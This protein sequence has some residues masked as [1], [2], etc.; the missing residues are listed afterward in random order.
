MWTDAVVPAAVLVTEIVV[1][2]LTAVRIARAVAPGRGEVLDRA[3]IGLVVASAHVIGVLL[4]LGAVGVL[5]RGPVLAAIVL[6]GAC[7]FRLVPRV[8]VERA[9]RRA[10]RPATV[11]ASLAGL[12][13]FVLWLVS[14]VGSPSAESDTNQYHLPNAAFWMRRASLWPLPPAT[15]GYFTATYPSNGELAGLWLML[16]THDDRLAYVAPLVFAVLVVLGAAL[17]ARELGGSAPTGALVGIAVAT[18]PLVY[19]T[20]VRSLMVDLPA[21]A[22]LVAGLALGLGARRRGDR[23]R[24]V[25]AGVAFGLAIG[26]KYPA[27][28]PGVVG[29]AAVVALAPRR[30]RVRAAGW[31]ALGAAPMAVFWYLRTWIATGNPIFPKGVTVAGHALLT[32]GRSPLNLYATSVLAHIRTGNT[33]VLAR[34]ARL[35]RSELGPALLLIAAGVA[36]VAWQLWSKRNRLWLLLAAIVGISALSYLATPF[37]GGGPNGLA[38]LVASQLRYA[39]P[40]AFLAAAV[41]GSLPG[42]VVLPPAVAAIA[43]NVVQLVRGPAF[44][45]DIT[46]SAAALALASLVAVVIV[47]P[48]VSHAAGSYDPASWVERMRTRR[49]R[50]LAPVAALGTA[51]VLVAAVAAP[52]A[53]LLH[54]VH[55]RSRRDLVAA[56]L[57][58]SD[59]PSRLV[60]LVGVIDVRPSLGPQLSRD[61]V[62][63]R[64]VGAAHEEP[65]GTTA[66]LDRQVAA[67]QPAVIV[68]GPSPIATPDGWA[69][70]GWRKVGNGSGGEVY[71][72]P[73]ASTGN[74]DAPPLPPVP[75]A[76]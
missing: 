12:W 19:S 9:P 43:F 67:L 74:V 31:V 8:Q 17:L 11:V 62:S 65:V 15:P 46:P 32:G 63:V 41:A 20:Q 72:P 6:V 4:L 51:A 1:V 59:A 49:P 47:A 38:F 13:F 68:V 54:R 52:A 24:L 21:A 48:L 39:L 18:S 25:R 57:G 64:G 29:M 28:L 3:V 69:P 26:A 34:W 60:L 27:L 2:V 42:R 55:P 70:P 30:A 10:M 7:A 50:P 16:P 56:A 37:T 73:P 23:A 22:G 53:A 40:F 14:S 33:E 58:R 71:V 61:V 36:V 76:G 5:R 66:A 75:S 35:G 44:R 45:A